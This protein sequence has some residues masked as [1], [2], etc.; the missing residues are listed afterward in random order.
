MRVSVAV[1]VSALVVAAGTCRGAAVSPADLEE[2]LPASERALLQETVLAARAVASVERRWN[3]DDSYQPS[4]VPCP[5]MVQGP[6]NVGLLR[7]ASSHEISPQEADYMARHRSGTRAGWADWLH[8]AGLD[9]LPGGIDKFLEQSQPRVGLAISG[10]GYRAMLHGAGVVEGFDGRNKTST[11]R[12]VGGLL[13]IVDYVAGL[14]GGSW[15]TGSYA[16]NNWPTVQELLQSIYDL[17][18][19]LVLPSHDKFGMYIDMFKDVDKK[20]DGGYDVTLTDFWGRALS[21][22]LLNQTEYKNE[23]QA[24]VF[25]DIVNTT[26]FKDASAPFPVV[27]AIAREPN[28][29]WVNQNATYVEYTPFEFGSW[30]PF[31]EAFVPVGY[32]GSQLADGKVTSKDGSCVSGYENFG[33]VVGS[34]STLFNGAYVKVLQSNETNTLTQIVKGILGDLSK[35]ENDVAPVPNPFSGYRPDSSMFHNTDT[36]RLVDGGEANHNV[37]LEPLMQPGRALDLII[38]IDASADTSSWPNGSSFVEWQTRMQLDMFKSMPFP[39]VPDVETFVNEGLNT[40]P[41][42][43]GCNPSADTITNFDTAYNHTVPPLIAFLPNYPY[44]AFGNTT[45]FQLEYSVDQQ[46]AVV[47]NSL[48]VATMGGLE[49]DW[50]RC[51]AC[52]SVLRPLQRSKAQIPP[53]CQKCMQKFCWDGKSNHTKPGN[54]TPPIGPPVFVTSHGAVHAEPPVTGSNKSDTSASDIFGGGDSAAVSVNRVGVQGALA[55]ALAVASAALAAVP[56]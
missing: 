31:L 38:G 32:L 37:P 8:R 35:S 18:Q 45:T 53:E 21:Y 30:Q 14:S 41:T 39:K 15:A 46:Q 25:S 29:L 13:Q 22:H 49:P 28:S 11:E 4:N 1:A 27:T 54:Y 52:A 20:K 23:G 42:F 51:L 6:D 19:N 10:G 36:L 5:P 17:E 12:G 44:S 16:I 26:K 7:N 40:R 2:F 33:F 50:H 56:W 43:F 47:L 9:N 55:A 24:T 3:P 34:S 48:D